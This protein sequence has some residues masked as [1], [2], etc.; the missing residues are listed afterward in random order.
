MLRFKDCIED[1]KEI[2]PLVE[3]LG[4]P[5]LKRRHWDEIFALTEA[6]VPLNDEGT[7]VR[8]GGGRGQALGRDLRAYRGGCASEW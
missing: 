2:M 4:N 8:V 7:G 6:D 3:E 5:A 1:F